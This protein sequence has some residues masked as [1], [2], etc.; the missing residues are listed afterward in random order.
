M[1]AIYCR[2]STEEQ[3][4]Y[5]YSL[6][7]QLERGKEYFKGQPALEFVD[8]GYSGEFIERPDLDKLRE[9]ARERQIKNLWIADPDRMARNLSH[10]LLL[11]DEFEKNGI[12]L[13]FG[14]GI[15]DSS[16]EGKLFFSMRGAIAE[17]EKAKIRERTMGGK[18]RKAKEGKLTLN[19]KPYGY[20]WDVTTKNY[21]IFEEE[22]KVV[23]YM[24][25]YYVANNVG[26]RNV[27]EE[28]R[29]LGFKNREG[30]PLSPIHINRMLGNE[31]YAGTKQ[32]FRYY[33]K[34]IGQGKKKKYK[35]PKEEWIP[36]PVPAIVSRDV[37]E[38]AQIKKGTNSVNSLRNTKHNYLVKNMLKCAHCGYAMIG[39]GVRQYHYYACMQKLSYASLDRLNCPAKLIRAEILDE[40]IW[41]FLHQWASGINELESAIVNDIPDYSNKIIAANAKKED[42][43]NQQNDIMKWYRQKMLTSEAAEK[44]LAAVQK[45][46]AATTAIIDEMQQSNDKIKKVTV[47]SADILNAVTFEDKRKVMLQLQA[48][49]FIIKAKKNDDGSLGFWLC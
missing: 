9:L 38:K 14:T 10:M 24:F 7:D 40:D 30:K 3:D 31:M 13:V 19:D 33:D 36:I 26:V 43:I 18:R 37:W 2:V 28:L 25:D 21:V 47:T 8:G 49:G 45:E 35:R 42:L 32:A 6:K 41:K 46:I 16:P 20:S 15:Y 23:R 11:A 22:A 34:L 27:A 17:F 4:K 39:S 44:E 48:D 1:N 12:N 5:G 29:S